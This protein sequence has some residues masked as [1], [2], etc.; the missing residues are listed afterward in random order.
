MMAG[1]GNQVLDLD[2]W[3]SN[4]SGK[5]DGEVFWAIR[6]IVFQGSSLLELDFVWSEQQMLYRLD[7]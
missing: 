6:P 1:V 5:C 4:V 3:I 2:C 7:K